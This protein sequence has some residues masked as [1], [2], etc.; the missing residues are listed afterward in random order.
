M[1]SRNLARLGSANV[2]MYLIKISIS[3]A[4]FLHKKYDTNNYFLIISVGE[5]DKYMGSTV[6]TASAK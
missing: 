5:H 4:T 3:I 2:C 1:E 6:L